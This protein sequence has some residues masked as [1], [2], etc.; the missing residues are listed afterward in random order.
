MPLSLNRLAGRAMILLAL[1][2]LVTVISG[3]FQKPQPDEGT[4]AHIFQLSV[5]ALMILIPLFAATANWAEPKKQI[6][7]L[8]ITG[9]A[10][11]LAFGALYYLEHVYWASGH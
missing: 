10:L 5:V 9:S 8:A 2:A 4:G 11:I 1:L 3:Y 6:T 7:P